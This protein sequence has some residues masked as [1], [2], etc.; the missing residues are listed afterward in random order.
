MWW[1]YSDNKLLSVFND[2]DNNLFDFSFCITPPINDLFKNSS[3][4]SYFKIILIYTYIN[5]SVYFYI[6]NMQ[7]VVCAKLFEH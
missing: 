5:M 3:F 1:I 6:K 4:I 2:L 7:T